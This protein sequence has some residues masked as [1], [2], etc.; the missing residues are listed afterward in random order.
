MAD[1]TDSTPIYMLNVL[2]FK[3]EGG[4][5]S[6]R[7]YLREVQPVVV[8]HGGRKLDTYTPDLEIIGQLDADV[9]FFVEWPSWEAFQDFIHDEDFV[10][11]R[12]LR[13]EALENSLLIRCRKRGRIRNE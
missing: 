8:K 5:D 11:V 4:K 9:I 3:A 1:I 2:W 13:E 12:H 7:Q 10:A 6:Y